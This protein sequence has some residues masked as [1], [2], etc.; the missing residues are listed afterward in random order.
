MANQNPDGKLTYWY[1]GVQCT[2][3]TRTPSAPI[4]A[5][6]YWYNGG[7]QGFLIDSV[8]VVKPRNFAILVGF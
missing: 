5:E 8:I 7:P 3:I 4:G 6:N 1:E 2:L